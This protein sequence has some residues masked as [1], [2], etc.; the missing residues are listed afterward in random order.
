[1]MPEPSTSIPPNVC[2]PVGGEI[3][4]MEGYRPRADHEDPDLAAGTA[5]AGRGGVGAGAAAAAAAAPSSDALHQSVLFTYHWAEE[6]NA[7]LY[8]GRNERWPLQNESIPVDWSDA[9][10][11]FGVEWDSTRIQ[12]FVDG[13]LRHT[14]KAGD[15]KSMF[16]P[17]WPFYMILNT[18]I[19]PWADASL[20]EDFP[21]AHVVDRVTWCSKV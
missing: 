16:M 21:V 10:H 4:I 13:I 2:W 18:A 5:D 17:A 3:D 12:W 11:T 20:D 19:T 8:D 15:P 6:C 9:F 7:D 14:R 1:M